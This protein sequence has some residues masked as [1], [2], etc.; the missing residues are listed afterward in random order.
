[1]NEKNQ[2]INEKKE[3][4]SEWIEITPEEDKGEV[5]KLKENQSIQGLLIEKKDSTTYKGTKIYKIKTQ[6]DIVPKV[7]LGTTV[8]DRQLK[9]IKEGTEI[10]IKRL[11]DKRN[12][13]GT[14]YQDYQT[15]HKK[16]EEQ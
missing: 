12:Q 13:Q 7:L 16:Q 8:L 2:K 9:N 14:T 6:D 5:I 15:F 3:K 1:M 11:E 4:E 10:K